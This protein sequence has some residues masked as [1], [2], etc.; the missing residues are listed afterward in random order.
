MSRIVSA[1]LAVG[2]VAAVP[3]SAQSI[4]DSSGGRYQMQPVEG[5]I[6]RLDTQT[7][8]VDLCRIEGDALVCKGS[9]EGRRGDADR[10]AD[11]EARVA[12]LEGG[13]SAVDD[14][15]AADQAIKT[16]RQVFR[17][18]ADIVRDLERDLGSDPDKAEGDG[19]PGRT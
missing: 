15:D 16:M 10:I 7:G 13:K 8:A 14:V 17:G 9:S 2:M 6:A 5:G 4:L 1:L 12:A 11:L 19:E 18:F 3:A